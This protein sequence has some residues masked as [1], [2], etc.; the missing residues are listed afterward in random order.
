MK[1]ARRVWT[2][3]LGLCGVLIVAWGPARAQEGGPAPGLKVNGDALVHEASKSKFTPPKGWEVAAPQSAGGSAFLSLRK[4]LG[5]VD[6]SIS[7]TPLALKMQDAVDL[8]TAHL[9]QQYGKEKVAKR[10]P[11]TVADK[12]VFVLTVDDGPNR[13]G[14]QASV[15]YLFEAGPDERSRWKVTVRGLV[16]KAQRNEGLKT[17]EGL[18]A[19]FQW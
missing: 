11:L 7:W 8:E 17:V 12:P 2:K 14:K 10:D 1:S 19:N 9:E 16:D 6:V 4:P 5:G 13:N 3:S 15:L 18:L